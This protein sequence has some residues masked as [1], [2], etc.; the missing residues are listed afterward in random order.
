M[1]KSAFPPI[2]AL[3]E[4]FVYCPETG[5]LTWRKRFG[6]APGVAIFNGTH[7]GKEAGS[8]HC[9]GY[10]QVSFIWEGVKYKAL[11]HRVCFAIHY[12][13]MPDAVD[14]KNNSRKDN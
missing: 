9:G 1:P 2:S 13:Y 12:G 4:L 6:D 3:K 7:A 10:L 8:P 11:V 14:H 5:V